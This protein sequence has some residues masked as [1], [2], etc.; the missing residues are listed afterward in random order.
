ME[1]ARLQA[2]YIWALWDTSL[3]V[4]AGVTHASLLTKVNVCA[5][6]R[7]RRDG[8]GKSE[9]V[10]DYTVMRLDTSLSMELCTHAFHCCVVLCQS[11]GSECFFLFKVISIT[12]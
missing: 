7:R 11:H 6:G 9:S 3:D 5:A 10:R 1:H 4:E 2:G 8:G 12:T